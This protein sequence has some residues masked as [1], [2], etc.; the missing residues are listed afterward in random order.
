MTTRTFYFVVGF[1]ET[2]P[3]IYI[4]KVKPTVE[5]DVRNIISVKK[6]YEDH[7]EFDNTAEATANNVEEQLYELCRSYKLKE[8]NPHMWEL[9]KLDGINLLKELFISLDENE[10]AERVK[11]WYIPLMKPI[12]PIRHDDMNQKQNA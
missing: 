11:F 9:R 7:P 4:D 6:K 3:V 2:K 5:F 10:R 8:I 1:V 12:E